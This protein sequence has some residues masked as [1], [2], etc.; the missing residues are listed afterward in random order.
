M[1]HLPTPKNA[2]TNKRAIVPYVC[3]KDYDGGPF[4]TYP[5][6]EGVTHALPPDGKIPGGSPYWQHERTHPTPKQEQEDFLQRW[7][8]FGLIHELLGHRYRPEDL[9]RTV[10]T[11]HGKTSI[12][13]TS[14]LVERLDKWID[15]MHAGLVNP[16]H[17]YEHISEC[18]RLAFATIYGAGPD[19][20]PHIKL[21][22]AS[23][24]ELFALAA[25]RAYNVRDNKCPNTFC[26]LIDHD[27]WRDPMLSSGWCPSQIKKNFDSILSLQ[28]LHFLTLLGQPAPDGF[29][30]RCTN[31]RCSAYQND[32]ATYKTKHVT[33]C[34]CEHFSVDTK[35]LTEILETGSLPLLSIRKGDT[36]NELSVELVASQST[37]PYIALSHVW[38]DGLGNPSENA[39][40][41]CQLD[42]LH[43]IIS[44][45]YARVDPQAVEE[46]L[47][48]CDTLCCPV[49]TG[50]AKKIA[51]AQMKKTYLEATRVL[52]LDASLRMYD[53][54]TMGPDEACIR[55]LNSGWTRR[56]WTLQEGALPAKNSRLSFLFKD[57]AINVQHLSQEMSQASYSS[58]GRKG[59]ATNIIARLA[60]FEAFSFEYYGE[61]RGDLGTVEA[62]LQHRSVS[63][64]S[65]EPLLIANLLDLDVADVLNGSCPMAN[66]ANVGCDHSRI[67]RLWLLMPTAFRGIPRNVLLRVGPRL[68]EPGFRWAPSTLLYHENLNFSL[69]PRTAIK[70]ENSPTTSG[71]MYRPLG[72]TFSTLLHSFPVLVSTFRSPL[73]EFFLHIR[74]SLETVGWIPAR[75]RNLKHTSLVTESA[76]R[77]IPTSRGLLVRFTGYGFS[78]AH[79][80]LGLPSN[81]W[82][83]NEPKNGLFSRGIDG[84]WYHINRRLPAEQDSFLSTKSVHAILQGEGEHW[85]T[86][87]ESAF[88]NPE[89][90]AE[91]KGEKQVTIGLLVQLLSD[92]EGIKYV[93][94]KLHIVIELVRDSTRKLLEAAYVSA[95]QVSRSLPAEL[96]AAKSDGE[97]DEINDVNSPQFKSV[98]EVLEQEIRR[99]AIHNASRDVTAAA[100][101]TLSKDGIGLFR[102]L[103]AMMVVGVCGYLGARTGEEQEWCFD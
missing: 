101:A 90:V 75:L 26:R 9:I 8:F 61:R 95:K 6:R 83:V 55:I 37:S 78:M 40:P 66:C 14:G 74:A 13:L 65:D 62:A 51:L 77:G 42:F 22:L 31:D 94:S 18:L 35:R 32:L 86:H 102:E 58:I 97:Q 44:E 50:K 33:G 54:K 68:S 46:I 36:F 80:P 24:G 29:H 100:A 21:S 41:R 69:Y 91:V 23:L 39:L 5:I 19:F 4:L 93:Q 70:K 20:D 72:V 34:N 79:C 82:N 38:A 43:Q 12:V 25:N 48:W 30:R 99:V 56:L 52:V 63:V 28:T 57:E 16:R 89:L 98:L 73:A 85:I 47:L 10:E 27:Y 103:I 1:D 71:F 81:P 49:E 88:N 3:L 11:D 92:E 76:S 87:V 17:T 64:P 45:Y 53:F 84:T 60:N 2:I 15:D 96:L 67:H 7:L 59:L